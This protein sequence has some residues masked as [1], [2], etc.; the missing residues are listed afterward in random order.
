MFEWVQ[1]LGLRRSPIHLI[2]PVIDGLIVILALYPLTL[3]IGTLVSGS[4]R[5]TS[6]GLRTTTAL[7]PWWAW[8]ITFTVGGAVILYCKFMD[9]K[10][11]WF[12]VWFGSVPFFFFATTLI[13]TFIKSLDGDAPTAIKTVSVTGSVTYTFVSVIYVWLAYRLYRGTRPA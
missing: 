9:I 8:G 13:T 10:A 2:P 6:P 5:F 11:L 12:F 7:M 1:R 3:G 4:T